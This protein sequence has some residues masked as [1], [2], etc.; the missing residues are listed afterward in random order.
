VTIV[1]ACR[2][3]AP[4]RIER[5]GRSN[6]A[7]VVRRYFAL[8]GSVPDAA[9]LAALPYGRIVDA[10]GLI[11]Y[12]LPSAGGSEISD[13]G[14]D[15]GRGLVLDDGAPIVD[16]ATGTGALLDFPN[17]YVRSID[18]TPPSSA[19][20]YGNDAGGGRFALDQLDGSES[21]GSLDAGAVSGAVLEPDF[22][23]LHPSY[24]VSSDAGILERR[25]DVDLATTFA[26][27]FLRAGLASASS[28][29]SDDRV[30]ARDLD[31]AHLSYATASRRYLTFADFSL[32]GIGATAP[33]GSTDQG[34]Y[35]SSYLSAD[36]RIEHPGDVLLAFG[37]S[38][39]Q[40]SAY[41]LLPQADELSGHVAQETLYAQATAGNARASAEAGLGLT[42]TVLDESSKT[43]PPGER[44]VLVP[45]I[46]AQ[47]ELG[48]DAYVRGGLSE[49]TRIP[50]LV[51][52]ASVSTDAEAVGIDRGTLLESALGYDAGRRIIAETI[53][54]REFRQG[55]EGSRLDGI[56]ASLAWQIAPL[57]SLRAW[58]LRDDPNVPA[59]AASNAVAASRQI[60]WAT[61]GADTPGLRFDLI[62]HRDVTASGAELGLDGDALLP[63][64][65]TYAL[66]IGT[67]Q[68]ANRTYYFGLRVT[69]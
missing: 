2:H 24:G 49:S 47:A 40:E 58:T 6:V 34:N 64:V 8:E 13:R 66:D 18:V 69:P 32:S 29:S 53:V 41:Y 3:C 31:L 14:L 46:S 61:Y 16:L 62:A 43:D 67:V 17:R 59:P 9:D 26:G 52:A 33:A 65:P 5:S 7:I 63:L 27:G 12:A 10:L 22:G 45:S 28:N 36:I 57:V 11:P 1:V 60:L 50:S 4:V 54:Y 42:N 21:S 68:H 25:A 23:V 55:F 35:R 30:P 37:L 51:D 56:G 15:G 48:S 38:A 39:T 44:L 19:F 20:A